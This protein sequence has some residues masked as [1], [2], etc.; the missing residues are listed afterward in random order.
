MKEIWRTQK[1]SSFNFSPENFHIYF[2]TFA[3]CFLYVW[4]K[5]EEFHVDW[6]VL[7]IETKPKHS[8]K[9]VSNIPCEN[10]TW[11]REENQKPTSKALLFVSGT[12][13]DS[14]N[15]KIN[16]CPSTKMEESGGTSAMRNFSSSFSFGSVPTAFCLYEILINLFLPFTHFMKNF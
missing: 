10:E 2:Y 3:M 15:M 11:V 12:E 8:S 13:R 4:K 1:T 14:S 16:N 6:W 9:H 5:T 7:K